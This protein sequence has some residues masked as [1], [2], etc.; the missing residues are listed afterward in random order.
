MGSGGWFGGPG[1]LCVP[2]DICLAVQMAPLPCEVFIRTE[3]NLI[4]GGQGDVSTVSE[5]QLV[6]KEIWYFQEEQ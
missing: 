1:Q 6:S 5:Y 2:W 3:I 4:E